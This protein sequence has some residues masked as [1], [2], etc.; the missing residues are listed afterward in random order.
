[1]V[2]YDGPVDLS[3]E[4]FDALV[5]DAVDALPP[6]FRERLDT[7]AIVVEDEPTPEELARVGA[8]GLYGLYTGVPRTAW[9]ATDVPIPSRITIYRGPHVRQYRDPDELARAVADTVR[10]EVAH[11]FGISDAR[12]VELA[13][14]RG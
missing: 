9:G 7:V 12:L 2:A 13:R 4:S 3:P 10:H 6:S 5:A 14:G 8:A 1:M 11:H